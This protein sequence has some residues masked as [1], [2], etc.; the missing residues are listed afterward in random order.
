I[1]LPFVFIFIG[2][3]FLIGG[4][5]AFIPLL[6]VPLIVFVSWIL[7]KP[8]KR[9]IDKTMAESNQKHAILVEALSGLDTIK[10]A[11]AQSRVQG[12]WERLVGT[13]AET[14]GKA[15][16]VATL[17]SSVVQFIIQMNTV[18]I[19]LFGVHM[20]IEKELTMG[21]LIAMSILSGRALGPLSTVS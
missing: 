4:P 11:G 15:R 9:I 2:V 1:D 18:V 14:S 12:R 8:L 19:V 5:L 17:A 6:T 10:T 7:Q 13:T 3:M 21:A 16:A 20:I